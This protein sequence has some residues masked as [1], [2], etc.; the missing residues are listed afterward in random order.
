[1]FRVLGL[2][3]MF[4]MM[5]SGITSW[6]M[7]MAS[8]LWKNI[9]SPGK[10]YKRWA[11]IPIFVS[12]LYCSSKSIRL[13][14]A[15]DLDSD[16]TWCAVLLDAALL[17]GI[18]HL[19]PD[20]A[21]IQQDVSSCTRVCHQTKT[22]SRAKSSAITITEFQKKK[23]NHHRPKTKLR[24]EALFFHLQ[25]IIQYIEIVFTWNYKEIASSENKLTTSI[26][27]GSKSKLL[28]EQKHSSSRSTLHVQLMKEQYQHD[29]FWSVL[30]FL[31]VC[32][33]V[34]LLL[35]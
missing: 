27:V 35:L 15:K 13:S 33:Q 34:S 7:L 25:Q 22:N 18:V 14:P 20:M 21:L 2:C 23:Y 11:V 29:W 24:T 32:L 31:A 4:E 1:M 8:A 16:D 26:I 30:F 3:Y 10:S 17:R 6:M 28:I 9:Y 19:N 12:E 5:V